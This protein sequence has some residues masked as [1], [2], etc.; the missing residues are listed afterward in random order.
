[1]F[2]IQ[3]VE[4]IIHTMKML[5]KKDTKR[6][7]HILL[8]RNCKFKKEIIK[9]K[10]NKNFFIYNYLYLKILELS[11]MSTANVINLLMVFLI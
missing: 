8:S 4:L 2:I 5:L 1:M 7:C 6:H 3:I 11:V 9:K 10:I